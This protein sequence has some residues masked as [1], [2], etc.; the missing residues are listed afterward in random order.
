MLLSVVFMEHSVRTVRAGLQCEDPII[1]LVSIEFKRAT[2]SSGGHR[3]GPPSL[4][5]GICT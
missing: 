5:S 1:V 2:Q 3:R 4:P